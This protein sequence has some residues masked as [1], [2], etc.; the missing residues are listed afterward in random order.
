MKLTLKTATHCIPT[1]RVGGKKKII[2]GSIALVEKFLKN[3]GAGVY[4]VLLQLVAVALKC[5][6]IAEKKQSKNGIKEYETGSLS[7]FSTG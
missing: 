7:R 4:T 3:S 6:P 1:V 2:C 5:T